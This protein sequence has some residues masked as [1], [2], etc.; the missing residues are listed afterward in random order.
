MVMLSDVRETANQLSRRYNQN[1]NMCGLP[2]R[3]CIYDCRPRIKAVD[4]V[5]TINDTSELAVDRIMAVDR[6][7]GRWTR[8]TCIVYD[9]VSVY[10][11]GSTIC[12]VHRDNSNF[13]TGCTCITGTNHRLGARQ[14]HKVTHYIKCK[15]TP[16]Q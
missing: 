9:S 3:Y 15:N 14:K 4:R 10:S 2:S 5:I 8:S 13:T 1:H 7:G 16:K 12:I 6:C 11:A